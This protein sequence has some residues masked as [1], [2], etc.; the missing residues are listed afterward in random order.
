[1]LVLPDESSASISLDFLFSS[2]EQEINPGEVKCFDV[3]ILDDAVNE[4]TE[5]IRFLVTQGNDTNATFLL[6]GRIGIIDNDVSK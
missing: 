3:V 5:E 2:S 1:M 6:N 4:G